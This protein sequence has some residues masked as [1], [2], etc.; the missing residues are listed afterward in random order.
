MKTTC[1]LQLRLDRLLVLCLVVA[2]FIGA[3]IYSQVVVSAACNFTTVDY[4]ILVFKQSI[5]VVVVI[6]SSQFTATE[7]EGIKR[8]FANWSNFS[9]ISGTCTGVT[10]TYTTATTPPTSYSVNAPKIYMQRGYSGAHAKSNFVGDWPYISRVIIT[11][12]PNIHSPDT[13]GGTTGHEIGHTFGLFDC[14]TCA[15]GTTIMGPGGY[16]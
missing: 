10:F 5:S 15:S 4:S 7:Q 6:N 2:L 13:L 9:S 8:A 3:T 14:P 16:L 12:D 1:L 11:V